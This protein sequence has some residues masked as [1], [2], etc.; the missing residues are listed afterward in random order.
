DKNFVATSF[1]TSELPS[2]NNEEE[3]QLGE[4]DEEVPRYINCINK[5]VQV[6]SLPD[7]MLFLGRNTFLS[8]AKTEKYAKIRKQLHLLHGHTKISLV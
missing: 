1:L 7:Q 2:D 3:N 6:E 8:I 5:W 4:D